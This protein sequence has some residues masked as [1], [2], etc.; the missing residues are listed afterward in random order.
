[1]PIDVVINVKGDLFAGIDHRSYISVGQ[2]AHVTHPDRRSIANTKWLWCSEEVRCNIRAAV[3]AI[4]GKDLAK[5]SV[6]IEGEE[7]LPV[8]GVQ[9]GHARSLQGF[10]RRC[11]P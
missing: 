4:G 2:P 5:E 3:W 10:D 9:A 7:S 11:C 8:I 1:M 6:G